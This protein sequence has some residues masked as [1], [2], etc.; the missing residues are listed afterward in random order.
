MSDSEEYTSGD[1]RKSMEE[2]DNAIFKKKRLLKTP[3]K[4][5]KCS[6]SEDEEIKNILKE[7]LLEVREI[8][9][10]NKENREQIEKLQN[11]VKD[12]KLEVQEAQQKMKG[13]EG[14]LEQYEK[15]KKRNNIVIKGLKIH[16]EDKREIKESVEEFIKQNLKIDAKPKSVHK[17]NNAVCVA[18]CAN[19]EEKIRILENK[20]KLRQYKDAMIFIE[21][22]LTVKEREEQKKIRDIAKQEREKGKNV[23][24]GFNRLTVDGVRWKW[25]R[26]KGVLEQVEPAAKN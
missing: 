20:N 2:D 26:N 14:K 8:R 10:E 17:I 6:T 1:K 12:L 23:Q 25:N 22:D 16:A 11:E 5:G 18:E 7:V 15:D 3:K 9:R 4:V 13:F 19:F 21:N 24:I